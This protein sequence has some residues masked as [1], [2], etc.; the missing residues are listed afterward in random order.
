MFIDLLIFA[1]TG[2]VAG[3][4]AGLFGVGGGL[5]IVPILAVVMPRLGVPTEVVM[6][7]AIGTSLGVIGFTSLSSARAH[8]R[9]GSV[10][11]RV[12]SSLAPGLMLGAVIGA[13]V[14][15]LLSGAALRNIVG[16]GALA[17]AAQM[18]LVTPNRWPP[19]PSRHHAPSWALPAPSSARRRR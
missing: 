12:L 9:R 4:M 1:A 6:Q 18:A 7:V 3:V 13:Q 15:D 5:T 17:I 2:V 16:F 10:N 19:M 14:A 8:Q 11:W